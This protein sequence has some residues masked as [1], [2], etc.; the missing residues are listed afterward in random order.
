M[1]IHAVKLI[2]KRKNVLLSLPLDSICVWILCVFFFLFL[3]FTPYYG[4]IFLIVFVL[5]F[6]FY[7]CG[8]FFFCLF[9]LGVVLHDRLIA[10]VIYCTYVVWFIVISLIFLFVIFLIVRDFFWSWAALLCL[11]HFV[12]YWVRPTHPPPWAEERTTHPPSFLLDDPLY[13]FAP[14]FFCSPPP[15]SPLS[16]RR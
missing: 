10:L 15:P 9:V 7:F 2:R 16:P 1:K 14:F 5:W 8:S 12:R 6:Y 13:R 3:V 11:M 4:N